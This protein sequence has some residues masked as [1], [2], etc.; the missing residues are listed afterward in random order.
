V[1]LY[2]L[3]GLFQTPILSL[4][5][6][7]ERAMTA[8][9]ES[10][11]FPSLGLT[12]AEMMGVVH[13]LGLDPEVLSIDPGMADWPVVQDATK[14]YI[15]CGLPVIAALELAKAGQSRPLYHAV[16][17]SGYRC[18]E[19]LEVK[20]LYVHDD[21]IGPYSPVRPDRG[22]V[23]WRN[24]WV[25][26]KGY[27][28]VSVA[29][30]IIPVY[31]KIRLAFDRIYSIYLEYRQKIRQRSL[32]ADL[33]LTQVNPYK[34]DLQAGRLRDKIDTLTAPFPR[35]L[36]VIRTLYQGRPVWDSVFDGTAVYPEVF[37]TIYFE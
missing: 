33:F 31:P 35:F 7:T 34:R 6:I 22:F 4:S 23:S 10:R 32:S 30:L 15:R 29:K 19:N 18:D 14:A 8:A 12:L 3:S 27:T 36:W 9:S 20:E 24:E 1:S 2:P 37:R 26:K 16:V 5:E 25:D 13:G 21:Q 11:T 17:I 28:R